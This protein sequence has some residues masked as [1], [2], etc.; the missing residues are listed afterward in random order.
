MKSM[1]V[2]RNLR[3]LKILT[4]TS[5]FDAESQFL[6]VVTVKVLL[7][8]I[9]EERKRRKNEKKKRKMTRIVNISGKTKVNGGD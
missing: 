3:K 1:R 4:S 5:P 9:V 6:E 2:M 8:T 7:K